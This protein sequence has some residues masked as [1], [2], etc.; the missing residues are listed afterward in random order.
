M[1]LNVSIYPSKNAFTRNP[2][3]L[4]IETSSMATYTISGN[5]IELFKGN[6]TGNF[7]VNISEVVETILSA[8]DISEGENILIPVSSSFNNRR[9]IKVN[10]INESGERQSLSFTA[11]IGGI[12][13]RIFQMLHKDGKDIFSIKFLNPECNFFFTTRSNNWKIVLKETEIFPLMFIYQGFTY[14]KELTTGRKISAENPFT[15]YVIGQPFA[16]DLQAVRKKFFTDYNL[17]SNLFEIYVDGKFSCQIGIEQSRTTRERYLLKFLNSFG[18]YELFEL[19]GEANIIS[20]IDE[21]DSNVYKRYNEITDDFYSERK[22]VEIQESVTIK[23]GFK[24]PDEIRFLLD[25][26]S[27]DDVSLIGYGANEIKV[28][29]SAEELSFWKT[30]VV[31]QNI[32]LKLTFAE[33]ES[34]PTPDITEMGYSKPRVH[35][36]QFSKQF[37]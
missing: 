24:R 19:E 9:E 11:W 26:L 5:D 6:G 34:N 2:I 18:A 21:E 1:S 14:I 30:P 20:T 4:S 10:V 16:L 23:T 27:S 7:R 12:S 32:T 22:R 3:F 15:A 28:I 25:L 31:P 36:K 29:P 8:P 17:L 13:K 37:N 35:S 33:T